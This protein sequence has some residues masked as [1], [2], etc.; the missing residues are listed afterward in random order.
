MDLDFLDFLDPT[1]HP[2]TVPIKTARFRSNWE[3]SAS[4]AVSVVHELL[5]GTDLNPEHLI[6]VFGCGGDRDRGKRPEMGR[7]AQKYADTYFVTSDNPRTEDPQAIIDDIL[8]GMDR[9]AGGIRVEVDR[10]KAS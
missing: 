3:L 7:I 6:A 1:G 9:N 5:D 10:K 4:R 2:D 8:E